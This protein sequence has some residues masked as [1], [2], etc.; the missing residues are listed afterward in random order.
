MYGVIA[1]GLL[2]GSGEPFLS[3]EDAKWVEQ[4]PRPAL[5]EVVKKSRE[6]GLLPMGEQSTLEDPKTY[7]P[8]QG[9]YVGFINVM[10]CRLQ[11]ICIQGDERSSYW[12]HHPILY[13]F[14]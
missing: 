6:L 4:L 11:G 8:G 12:R 1:F 10:R 7:P 13:T 2:M 14:P 9:Y 5:L 3:T